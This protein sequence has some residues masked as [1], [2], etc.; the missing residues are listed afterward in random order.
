MMSEK[1]P[2]EELVL[3]KINND[4]PPPI[5]IIIIIQKKKTTWMHTQ[6]CLYFFLAELG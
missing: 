3:K 2:V 4:L 6:T 5:K 1:T